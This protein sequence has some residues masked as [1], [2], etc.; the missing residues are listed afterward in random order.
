[1]KPKILFLDIET[2]LIEGR[3]FR[4]FNENIDPNLIS[5]D[6][7]I[8]SWSAKWIG[9]EKVY[10]KSTQ[11]DSEKTIL[12][13]L[14]ELMEQADILVGHNIDKFDLK[15]IVTRMH[16]NNIKPVHRKKTIDTLKIARKYFSFTSNKLEYLAIFLDVDAKKLTHRMFSGKSLWL[17]C[18]LGNKKA[19][20]EMKQYN[21]MDVVVLEKVYKKIMP[22]TK[23]KEADFVKYTQ[24]CQCGSTDFMK[25][26]HAFDRADGVYK[27]F[28]CKECGYEISVKEKK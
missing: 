5:K 7:T 11:K 2:S 22:W 3:F 1:M 18:M 15:R 28:V 24:K 26:G 13:K 16:K 4:I 6:Y 10:F 14:K 25:N 8:L 27:R 20:K 19:W 12:L 9:K 21:K 23:G 17:E